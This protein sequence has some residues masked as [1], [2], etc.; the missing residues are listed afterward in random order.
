M[1]PSERRAAER[2]ETALILFF[3]VLIAAGWTALCYVIGRWVATPLLA[4]W[5]WDAGWRPYFVSILFCTLLLGLGVIRQRALERDP[6]R[7]WP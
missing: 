4:R 3:L 5:N 1:R 2:R 7:R 6:D